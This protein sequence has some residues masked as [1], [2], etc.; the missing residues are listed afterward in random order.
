[1]AFTNT[2]NVGTPANSEAPSGGASAIRLLKNA[3]QER[4]DADHYF[5]KSGDLVDDDT[6]VGFHKKA[7]LLVQ[8]SATAK[9]NA[10]I[11][12]TKDVSAK[13]EL[14]FKDEDDNEIQ[15]TSAGALN[16][17]S[18]FTSG[19]L[20]LTTRTGAI[21]GWTD[22]STTYADK[23]IRIS[24]TAGSTGGANTHTHAAGSYA[25]PSHTHTTTL[26]KGG[27]EQASAGDASCWLGNKGEHEHSISASGTGAVTGTSA[28]GDNV[29]A[30]YTVRCYQKD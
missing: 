16:V 20:L 21:S 19:D 14:H 10:G 29:P 23:F 1:M 2:Y 12:Y 24:A 18:A 26:I 5:T 3:L 13:A 11:L 17:A 9:A 27:D 8:T 6:Q 25:G 22:K 28:S 15:L 7:T 30:Y 4:I